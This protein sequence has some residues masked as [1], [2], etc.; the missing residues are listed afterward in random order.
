MTDV[1]PTATTTTPTPAT[2][3]PQAPPA[4]LGRRLGLSDRAQRS[5]SWLGVAVGVYV[6]VTAVELIGSGF[7][8]ATGDSAEQLFAFASNPFVALMVGVLFTAL[9]Q[10]SSTTTSV[11]VGLVAGG[12]PIEIAI[13]MLM[14]ANIGTTL[15]N[16]L[17]SLGAARD[18]ETFRRAFSAATVHDFFNLVA[19]AIFLPL[20][21]AFGLLERTSGWLAQMTSGTD[22]GFVATLFGAVGTVVDAVTEPLADL[23]AGATSFLPGAWHGVAMILLGIGL[24]LVVINWLGRLLKALLVGRAA[25]VLHGSIGR[26][27]ISGL[28]SGALVT[29][30]VQSSSTT[31]SLMIPLAGSGTFSLKQIYPFTVGANIGTTVTALIAAF[32][33]TGPEASVALQAAF[34]HMLFNIFAAVLVFGMPL[35]RQLPLRGA[36]W[37]GNLAATNKAWAAAWVLGVFIGIPLALIGISAAF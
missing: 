12:L 11:T 10:S 1:L 26:G 33:F 21:L 25:D 27:P 30:M 3:A 32:A 37:L 18:K 16:T 31:T 13:P 19:V 36:T 22:G 4:G 34:V 28:A 35:L 2:T 17:V 23:L 9:V 8:A 6:L 7:S 15:T 29:V 5:A 14:G 24:I 20:E